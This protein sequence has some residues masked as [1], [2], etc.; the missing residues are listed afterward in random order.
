MNFCKGV[1]WIFWQHGLASTAVVIKKLMK[2]CRLLITHV[3]TLTVF[4]F[5]TVKFKVLA[6]I[7]I[8]QGVRVVNFQYAFIIRVAEKTSIVVAIN[9]IGHEVAELV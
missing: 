1:G 5:A 8:V 9:F 6:S 4:S 2:G 3:V 7:T